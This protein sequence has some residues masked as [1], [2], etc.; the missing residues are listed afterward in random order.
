M[1]PSLS[2]RL[3]GSAL[4]CLP[5][6]FDV[7]VGFCFAWMIEM[8]GTE[9]VDFEMVEKRSCYQTRNLVAMYGVDL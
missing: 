1:F 2:S 7:F 9:K 3:L 5:C 4:L 8:R 6:A